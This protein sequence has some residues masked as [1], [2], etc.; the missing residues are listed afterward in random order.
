MIAGNDLTKASV[1]NGGDIAFCLAE[2]QK[3]TAVLADMNDARIHLHSDTLG[4]AWQHRGM[5]AEAFR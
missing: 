3:A 5:A 2:G 4:E 1:N